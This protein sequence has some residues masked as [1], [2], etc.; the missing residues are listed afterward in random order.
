MDTEAM[1]QKVRENLEKPDHDIKT[2]YYETGIFQRIARSHFLDTISLVVIGINAIWIAFDTDHNKADMLVDASF[3]FQFTEHGFCLFFVLE[4]SVR[5]LALEK[6]L[7]GLADSWFLFDTLIVAFMV[8]ETWV[9]TLVALVV[10]RGSGKFHVNTSIL[11]VVR[12]LRITRVARLARLLRAI[13]ELMILIKGMVAAGRAVFFT[14]SLMIMIIYVFAIAFTQMSR[15]TN[16]EA[17][18]FAD[19]TTSMNVLLLSSVFP[20]VVELVNDIGGE[21]FL[22]WLM[23]MAFL[24]LA[25]LTTMNMLVGVLVEVVSVVASCEKETLEVNY[26]KNRLRGMMEHKDDHMD[27]QDT[28]DSSGRKT[29][30]MSFVESLDLGL[31]EETHMGDK[32]FYITKEGFSQMLGKKAAVEALQNVGVDV[33]GLV[34]CTDYIFKDSLRL[35]FHDFM[36]VVLQLRGNNT[37][38]V[39]DLVDL[40]KFVTSLMDKIEGNIVDRMTASLERAINTSV[41]NTLLLLQAPRDV[42][43]SKTKQ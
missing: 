11:K 35:S 42:S 39:K 17:L 37:V 2:L 33:V 20:D 31:E 27:N 3:I 6:K 26:V 36:E 25:S 16:L 34:E 9:I 19:M 7:K 5:F 22:L 40:R 29:R 32:G 21:H 43:R 28:S 4:W 10:G 12:L 15:D 23:I 30:R 38:K 41:Q 1:K 14:L 18:H 13:P 8:I 24:T